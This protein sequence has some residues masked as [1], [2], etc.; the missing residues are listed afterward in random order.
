MLDLF[1]PS[2]L[3]IWLLTGPD[4][5]VVTR[6]LPG[7]VASAEL[8][9]HSA[10]ETLR[11]N[12]RI[13]ADYFAR[14]IAV[15]PQRTEEILAVKVMWDNQEEQS[16]E[17]VG[18]FGGIL[19]QRFLGARRRED[20][21]KVLDELETIR[22]QGN[23]NADLRHLLRKVQGALARNFETKIHA[24]PLTVFSFSSIA[25]LAVT[26]VLVIVLFMQIFYRVINSN[27]GCRL[28]P[29]W[30]PVFPLPFPLGS[31]C[32]TRTVF[33]RRPSGIRFSESAR[34]SASH[35]RLSPVDAV[36]RPE[37]RIP[38]SRHAPDGAY[39]G[40][41]VRPSVIG[42]PSRGSSLAAIGVPLRAPV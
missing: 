8:L 21:E 17:T 16:S 4:A 37:R 26:I 38:R 32:A 14:L 39:P 20:L 1:S 42:P 40:Q 25:I 41:E 19:W 28:S 12:G 2:E 36:T 11:R 22:E 30:E 9:A 15:R 24:P 6:A 5:E 27:F 29:A 34:G 13:N 18:D 3:R 7:D 33:I 35:D 23:L 31:A 10:V